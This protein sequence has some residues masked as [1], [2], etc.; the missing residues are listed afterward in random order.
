[1]DNQRHYKIFFKKKQKLYEEYLKNC[2]TENLATYKVY[3]NLFETIKRKS[4][5]I[6]YSEKDPTL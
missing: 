6:F 4:K 3:K 5:K 2:N 1:M